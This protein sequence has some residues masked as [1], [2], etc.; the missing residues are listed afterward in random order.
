[1]LTDLARSAAR[2]LAIG[3]LLAA[4]GAAAQSGVPVT[5]STAERAPVIK[6]V[7]LTGTVNAAR[8][9]N[10]SPTVAGQVEEITL[11]VGDR[12][13][14]GDPVLRMDRELA[15]LALES[16][17]A[18][19]EQA[20]EELADARRRLR[21]AQRLSEQRGIAETEVLS[22]QSEVRRDTAAVRRLEAEQQRH[23]ERLRR[24]ELTA[25][26][27]AVVSQRHAEVGEW[28][29]PGDPVVELVATDR[30]L[31]DF[32]VPQQY[33]PDV[34][35]DQAMTVT[36][37]ALP[38]RDLDGHIQAVVPVSDPSARTFLVRVS[39]DDKRIPMTPG[40]SAAGKLRLTRSQEGVVI[41]RDALLRYPDGR[42]TVWVLDNGGDTA[43]VDERNVDIGVAFDGRVEV[44]AGLA[45]GT[46][47]VVEGNEALQPGQRVE[48]RGR[49]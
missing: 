8:V 46:P 16:A 14:A 43:T 21:D 38:G 11:D 34:S 47:V 5:V 12:V 45:A 22:L 3:L 9:T 24:H 42:T 40:M 4:T 2:K 27:D 49:R 39:L 28:V 26:F 1:M 33:F 29:T 7:P 36:L 44:V 23:A 41:S 18:A 32:R 37:Q 30:L 35:V 19:T 25:P 15:R 48:V 10:L 17:R 6:V 20:R 31:V 13:R